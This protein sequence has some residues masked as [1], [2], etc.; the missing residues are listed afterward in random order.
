MNKVLFD[1]DGEDNLTEIPDPF[2][3]PKEEKKGKG[4]VSSYVEAHKEE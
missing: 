1:A 4:K 3:P 2:F